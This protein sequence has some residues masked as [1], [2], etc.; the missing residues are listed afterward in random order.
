[1][2]RGSVGTAVEA[3]KAVQ[4]RDFPA[5]SDLEHGSGAGAAAVVSGAV[6]V[7]VGAQRQ[8]AVRENT[9]GAFAIKAPRC[10]LSCQGKLKGGTDAD[11][12]PP[13]EVLYKL[14]SRP[15]AKRPIQAGFA[16]SPLLLPRLYRSVY[17][18]ACRVVALAVTM[19]DY[20]RENL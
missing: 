16:G 14:P 7:A 8:A 18:C 2:D 3:G 6:E 11:V 20:D 1:M 10:D 5:A 4:R 19:A 17:F 9:V 12:P 15:C 13:C